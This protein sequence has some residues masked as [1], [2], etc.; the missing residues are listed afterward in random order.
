MDPINNS[1]KI[2]IKT[3]RLHEKILITIFFSKLNLSKNFILIFLKLVKM[4]ILNS[5][6]FMML[7]RYI[8]VILLK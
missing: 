6:I 8:V 4:E 2:K 7:H 3:Y 1:L 5:V